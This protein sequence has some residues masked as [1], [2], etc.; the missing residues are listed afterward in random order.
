[1]VVKPAGF[2]GFHSVTA[3]VRVYRRGAFGEIALPRRC[4]GEVGFF[5]HP[6]VTEDLLTTPR[7]GPRTS[8]IGS[9]FRVVRVCGSPI[10]AEVRVSGRGAFGADPEV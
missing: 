2:I 4:L 8:E 3:A 6:G 9:D 5:G 10:S 1:M 7:C